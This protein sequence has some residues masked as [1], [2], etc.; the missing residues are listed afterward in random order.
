VVEFSCSP[1]A[2][3]CRSTV[4]RSTETTGLWTNSWILSRQHMPTVACIWE[5][6]RAWSTSAS[7]QATFTRLQYS[8]RIASQILWQ[9]TNASMVNGVS[10]RTGAKV[11]AAFFCRSGFAVA[12]STNALRPYGITVCIIGQEPDRGPQYT[13]CRDCEDSLKKVPRCM[14]AVLRWRC[15]CTCIC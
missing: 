10:T 6:I 7:S 1:D 9:G 15:A 14:Q 11:P 5:L 3:I 12:K 13:L 8:N 4:A 2:A